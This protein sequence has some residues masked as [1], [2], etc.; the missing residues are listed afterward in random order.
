MRKNKTDKLE[1]EQLPTWD[2]PFRA[3]GLQER[4]N[5]FQCFLLYRDAGAKRSLRK[6]SE[7]E[8]IKYQKLCDWSS[9]YKWNERI[10]EMI[11]Y[12]NEENKKANEM[13]KQKAV[14]MIKQRLEAKNEIIN[15]IFDVLRENVSQYEGIELDFKEFVSLL[16]LAMKVESINI[17]DIGNIHEVEQL[18][19]DGGID[20]QKIQAVIN[21]YSMVLES[22]NKDAIDTYQEM[23]KD[24]K[25]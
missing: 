10:E 8:N 20:A 17:S 12:E 22:E 18:F 3:E 1:L 4:N 11:Q 6:L 25:Y 13:I 9:K 15:T 24:D 7:S 21:N 16:N 23:M 5:A 19:K 2:K 14:E